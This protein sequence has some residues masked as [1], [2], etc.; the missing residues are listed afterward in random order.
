MQFQRVCN[1]EPQHHHKAGITTL[2]FLL[3]LFASTIGQS[4]ELQMKAFRQFDFTQGWVIANGRLLTT[5]SAGNEW[6][7][8]TPANASNLDGT[9]FL[10]PTTAWVVLSRQTSDSV[11][12]IQLAH[13]RDGGS[14][15]AIRP[16]TGASLQDLGGYARE[17]SIS[18]V[19]SL[20]GW[21]L[22]RAAT[23]QNFSRGILLVTADG[24]NSWTRL[25][26]PPIA[27]GLQFVTTHA[28]T[29]SGG[30]NRDQLFFT[31]DGGVTWSASAVPHNPQS[32]AAILQPPVFHDE[33]HGTLTAKVT[34]G[35]SS[36]VRSTQLR[37]EAGT[38]C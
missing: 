18:F 8:I 6:K 34:T 17:S 31:R 2:I 25:P 19:D 37:M 9:F 7:D 23:S 12:S 30:P 16:L 38:G 10:N 32:H 20:H 14:H 27:D 5:N 13:T 4:Q 21:V 33:F 15:W 36:V 24:G 22:L 3:A 28:G 35:E 29:L 26:D 11:S 1:E